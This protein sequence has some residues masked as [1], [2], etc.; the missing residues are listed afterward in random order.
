MNFLAHIHLSGTSNDCM[1]GNF[2]G[3][4]VKG[5]EIANYSNTVVQGIVL[6]RKIDEFTDTHPIVKNTRELI[7]P[8]FAKY[9]TVVS[10]VYYDHFLAMHWEKFHPT[11]LQTFANTIY[12]LLKS[13]QSELPDRS[14]RFLHY[15]LS[16]NILYNYNSLQGMHKVFYGLS[17]RAKFESGMEKAAFVLE[18]QYDLIEKDFFAFF[19]DLQY[20]VQNINPHFTIYEPFESKN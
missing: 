4:F 15:M 8:H 16:N 7:Q 9:A 11:P 2:I 5:K 3:D 6:H 17:N 14:Q 13:R 19:A 18:E 20:F 12:S 1:I 10:D